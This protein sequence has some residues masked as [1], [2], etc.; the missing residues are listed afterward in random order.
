MQVP[1][2]HDTCHRG[3]RKI[4]T[5]VVEEQTRR[6]RSQMASRRQEIRTVAFPPEVHAARTRRETAPNNHWHQRTTPRAPNRIHIQLRERDV[7]NKD[8]SR[9]MAHRRG[10]D[11]DLH[12]YGLV[13]SS[14][15]IGDHA[16]HPSSVDAHQTL[17]RRFL[18][19]RDGYKFGIKPTK[20]RMF[21]ETEDPI[22]HLHQALGDTLI[23]ERLPGRDRT[24]SC[25]E[26]QSPGTSAV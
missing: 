22:H 2:L 9:R 6:N 16:S 5:S 15:K 3:R 13:H 20:L 1:L 4:S 23:P 8:G 14:D 26:M 17:R 7:E 18:Q 11:P 10:K 21:E 25:R 12:H 24:P 19:S